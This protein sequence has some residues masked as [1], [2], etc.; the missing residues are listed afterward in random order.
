VPAREDGRS[1]D[2]PLS[3]LTTHT[4]PRPYRVFSPPPP[5]PH[6]LC[7]QPLVQVCVSH[8][9]SIVCRE[10]AV[11]LCGGCCDR[12]WSHARGSVVFRVCSSGCGEQAGSLLLLHT[13]V[14]CRWRPGSWSLIWWLH[15]N[16]AH[17]GHAC[18]TRLWLRPG[19]L[20][21]RFTYRRRLVSNLLTCHVRVVYHLFFSKW[22]G[23]PPCG[24]SLYRLPHPAMSL[25]V[26]SPFHA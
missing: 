15:S 5:P 17:S 3:D 13:R 18:P 19:P 20:L 16:A 6:L 24:H 11:A 21:G 14:L 25:F 7:A 9:L 10:G 22:C 26:S 4:R 12:S 2:H 23:V 8:T 1:C